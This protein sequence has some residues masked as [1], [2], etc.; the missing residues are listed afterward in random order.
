MRQ[1]G[2]LG[3]WTVT[4]EQDPIDDTEELMLIN[5]GSTATMIIKVDPSS[6]LADVGL[7][8]PKP[9]VTIADEIFAPYS[10]VPVLYAY[11]ITRFG[12]ETATTERWLVLDTDTSVTHH[13][14]DM[15]ELMI[16][17]QFTDRFVARVDSETG[18]TFTSIFEVSGLAEI[19]SAVMRE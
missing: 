17:M 10:P 16:N 7:M 18:D 8:W 4:Y 9:V 2:E 11:V 14:G 1:V 19:L 13:I 15:R 3:N 12:K 6:E 5:I